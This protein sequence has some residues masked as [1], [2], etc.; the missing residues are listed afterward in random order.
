M[1]RCPKGSRKCFSG[2]CVKKSTALRNK[3][4]KGTR[5]C[6]NKK[7]YMKTH[8]YHMGSKRRRTSRM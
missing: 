6:A 5:K 2:Q 8:K 1:P 4:A 3:C 7:C